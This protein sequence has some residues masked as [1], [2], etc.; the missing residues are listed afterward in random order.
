M[1]PLKRAAEHRAVKKTA[2]CVPA[3]LLDFGGDVSL[4]PEETGQMFWGKKG[5]AKPPPPSLHPSSLSVLQENSSSIYPF[6]SP[7]GATVVLNNGGGSQRLSTE[8]EPVMTV[9]PMSL[10]EAAVMPC[11]ACRPHIHLTLKHCFSFFIHSSA[12]VLLLL[13]SFCWL[14]AHLI[15]H[16][17][18]KQISAGPRSPEQLLYNYIYTYLYFTQSMVWSSCCLW[19]T[20]KSTCRLMWQIK[21]DWR[22]EEISFHIL[23]W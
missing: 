22:V 8:S 1:K 9:W 21:A 17:A 11:T 18:V 2:P 13:L 20:H 7:R 6:L 3:S 5:L 16:I 10:C 23:D 14:W 12:F 4:K 15:P 19:W